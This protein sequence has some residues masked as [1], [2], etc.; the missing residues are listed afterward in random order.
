MGKLFEV[1][2]PEGTTVFCSTDQWEKHVVE[3]HAVMS[4]N[5]PAV[6][7]TIQ[8]PDLIFDSA[9]TE[10]RSVY[11]KRTHLSTYRIHTKVI[12]ERIDSFTEQVVTSFPSKEVKGGIGDVKYK[13]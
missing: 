4:K 5:L 1:K 11:F 7:D 2:N 9:D 6:R 10:N 3:R 8:N 13:R 12:T